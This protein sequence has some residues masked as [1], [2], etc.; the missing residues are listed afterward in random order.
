MLGPVIAGLEA[1]AVV[2]VSA[3]RHASWWLEWHSGIGRAGSR[4]L[5]E[6]ELQPCELS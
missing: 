1:A 4:E 5:A 2:A 3:V 6:V